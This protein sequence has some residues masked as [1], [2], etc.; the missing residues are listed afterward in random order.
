[1]P[2]QAHDNLGV[3][4]KLCLA[5]SKPFVTLGEDRRVFCSPTCRRK[6]HDKLKRK[7]KRERNPEWARAELERLLRWKEE[8]QSRKIKQTKSSTHD[9]AHK[10]AEVSKRPRRG[11]RG[12]Q[13]RKEVDTNDRF[14]AKNCHKKV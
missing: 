8:H 11:H 1:M 4:V 3:Q 9:F 6:F 14:D 7:R 5:C 12:Q 13:T 10:N 2:K